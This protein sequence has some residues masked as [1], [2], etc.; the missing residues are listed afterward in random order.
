MRETLKPDH[1]WRQG[2]FGKEKECCV[3]CRVGTESL[4]Y[5]G[6]FIHISRAQCDNLFGHTFCFS[7]P[8]SPILLELI[9][10][11]KLF[12]S[13]MSP[14]LLY[15]LPSN[16]FGTI[17]KI[18]ITVLFSSAGHTEHKKTMPGLWEEPPFVDCPSFHRL[19]AA[20][21]IVC[22]ETIVFSMF[23]KKQ[24]KMFISVWHKP[25]GKP[26]INL[27]LP[28]YLRSSGSVLLLLLFPSHCSSPAT[29]DNICLFWALADQ[30]PW[31]YATE[32]RLKAVY[33]QTQKFGGT[34]Y[35]VNISIKGIFCPK[36][37]TKCFELLWTKVK[38]FCI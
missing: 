24:L 29:I 2:R 1:A 35:Q 28:L 21:I 9:L 31:N 23:I 4:F 37:E 16:N 19:K 18:Y 13:F 27:I 12:F 10:E 5:G 26:T 8:T 6:S 36:H 38:W 17:Q 20:H 33:S 15:L 25:V 3:K 7:K 22:V 14:L 11:R 30:K 32:S 34:S